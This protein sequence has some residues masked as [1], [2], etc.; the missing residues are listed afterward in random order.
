MIKQKFFQRY[1]L[2]QNRLNA[3]FIKY[4]FS[5]KNSSFIDSNAIDEI[6]KFLELTLDKKEYSLK[7]NYLIFL[8]QLENGSLKGYK[9]FR[10]LPCRGQRT[11]T[12]AKINRLK[13]K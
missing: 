8:K 9:R 3:L 10:G 11:K 4:G 1:G 13:K 2:G 6:E 7:R 12:N 5:L